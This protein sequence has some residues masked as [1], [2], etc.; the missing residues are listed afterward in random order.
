MRT[1][2]NALYSVVNSTTAV[3]LNR[4]IH[5]SESPLTPGY[6]ALVPVKASGKDA[7]IAY[8]KSLHTA[9]AYL[10]SEQSPWILNSKK[11]IDL[12]LPAKSNDPDACWESLNAFTLGNEPYLMAYE[13]KHGTFGF[14]KIHADLSIS[15]PYIFS[16]IRNAPTQGFTS[17][18]IY[19]SL[20]QIFF[21]GYDANTG[22]VNFSLVVTAVSPEGTAP[23][24][25]LNVWYHRW[26]K[27]WRNFAFFQLGGSNFFFKINTAKLN[28]NIDHMQDNPAM[29]SIEV[30]SYLQSQ[31]PNALQVTNAA[32]IPWAGGEPYLITY[33]SN[34]GTTNIYRIH[35]DCLG[36]SSVAS[37]TTPNNSSQM[38]TY[39]IKDESFVLFY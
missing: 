35:S 18:G 2:M 5:A 27:G 23:L 22:V 3:E 34:T 13:S 10:L 6:S 38:V 28:V 12:D 32:C 37:T 25:A 31:L 20:N 1:V 26:A 21:T 9:D 17:V 19:N 24:Q 36:W 7:L 15:K 4:L 30:G 29:G 39:R 11:S 16:L 14:F 33:V 8:N